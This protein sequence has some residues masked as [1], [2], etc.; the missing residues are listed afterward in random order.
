MKRWVSILAFVLVGLVCAPAVLAQQGE[1][2]ITSPQAT[3]TVSGMVD[4]T[5][6]VNPP[7][8]QQYFLEVAPFS[9]DPNAATWTPVTLPGRTPVTAG[10]IA[11]WDTRLV[12]DGVYS[13]RL[14]A[15]LADGSVRQ[16]IVGPMRVANGAAAGQPQATT[17]PPPAE[18]TLIPRPPITNELP[19]NV[20]GQMDHMSPEAAALIGGAGL[21]WMKFQIR[22]TI[23]DASLL[24]VARDR[25]NFAHENGFDILLSIP[26]DKF[27]LAAV[28]IPEYSRVYSEFVAQVAE[29]GP[30]AIQVWNEQNIDR[31]WP[32]QLISGAN[33]AALLQPAYTAIKAAN[34]DVMVVTGAPAP[35]G[36]FGGCGAGGC[37]DNVYYDQMAAAGVANFTDCV[38][39]HY[40]EGILPPT[41]LGGDPRGEYPTRYLQLMIQRAEFAFSV[42]GTPKPLCFTELGYLTG[43]GFAQALPA[44]FAWAAGNS[45]EDQANWL[46]DAIT[47]AANQQDAEVAL[48]I[49]FN[50][51]Y[52]RFV[53]DDPQGGFAIIRPDG[54]CPACDTIATLRRP[55]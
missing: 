28:G 4:V 30:G 47:V 7:N 42:R 10:L 50:V 18:P 55:A 12:A 2:T 33:Y 32:A 48:L 5:G 41:A 49:I 17:A 43:D 22:Y 3:T 53:E 39:V 19:L 25:I 23:G 11:Q 29:M 52:E 27:E 16:V 46:R 9:M 38:G 15:A 6:T 1:V 35:T 34:P 54:R 37:D 31:E 14:T 26:G 8:L 51:D 24:N 40:N 36:F 20:G 45:I 44:P 21:T 13:L